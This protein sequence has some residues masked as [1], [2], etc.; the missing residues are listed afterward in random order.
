LTAKLAKDAKTALTF[1]LL[2][3]LAFFAVD[4]PGPRFAA[5]EI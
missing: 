1:L 5:S 3:N 4:L 2:A